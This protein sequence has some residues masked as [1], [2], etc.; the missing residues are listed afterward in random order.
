MTFVEQAESW[1]SKAHMSGAKLPALMGLVVLV[2]GIAIF[3]GYHL[4]NVA[5]NEV[6]I[7]E[8]A[9]Q[10]N[11]VEDYNTAP[12]TQQ[13]TESDSTEQKTE[14]PV[15]EVVHSE[16]TS[17]TA[18]AP[19]SQSSA[20]TETPSSIF[21]H[22][23]G[24]VLTPG[25]VE[26]PAASRVSDAVSAAGGFSD[27]AA[28]DA[29]NLARPVTDGE[30]IIVPSFEEY[31]ATKPSFEEDSYET[32]A[33]SN[34]DQEFSL[35]DASGSHSALV[36]INTA[37]AAELQTLNGI[38]PSTAEKI[39]ADREACGPF[40]TIEDLMRVTGIGEK[41]FAAIAGSICVG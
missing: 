1:R 31:E 36:N 6:L 2:L 34:N 28:P 25:V 21:V 37:S 33:P 7:I 13:T 40:N 14:N 30:R 11:E 20:V 24:C 4:F 32:A 9:L 18:D 12:D 8:Q 22:V 17:T 39:I 19:S 3:A 26:L 10:G 27:L 41:K 35:I 16:Q 15:T 5:S 38:G 29:L 23:G